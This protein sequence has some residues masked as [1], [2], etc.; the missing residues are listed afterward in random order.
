VKNITDLLALVVVAGIIAV[1]ARNPTI[2]SNF[3]KG[4]S[5]LLGTALSGKYAGGK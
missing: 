5:T 3:F 2:V 1:L 4:S